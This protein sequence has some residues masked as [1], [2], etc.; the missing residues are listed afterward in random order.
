MN[1]KRLR[2][3]RAKLERAGGFVNIP[4]DLPDDIAEMFLNDL[5]SCPDCAAEI[6]KVQP[7]A[8][9]CAAGIDAA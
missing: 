2:K 4:D 6:E 9:G 1:G 5:L 8:Q 7:L 3:M